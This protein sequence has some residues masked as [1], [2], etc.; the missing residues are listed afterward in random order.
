MPATYGVFIHEHSRPIRYVLLLCALLPVAGCGGGSG[1]VKT[2]PPNNTNV[3]V[4]FSNS[5][6]PIA[7][8]EKFGNGAWSAA[9]VPTAN[10][11]TITLPQGTTNF[12][13]AYVCPQFTLPSPQ[14]SITRNEESVIQA[15]ISDGSAY[16]VS[17]QGNPPTGAVTGIVS[18]SSLPGATFV[19]IMGAQGS[20]ILSGNSGPVTGTLA[21]STKDI[22]VVAFGKLIQTPPVG[23]QILRS[24]SVP[25]AINGGS[26]VTLK[27]A[28][29]TTLQPLVASGVPAGFSCPFYE[30]AYFTANGTFIPLG[31]GSNAQYA[32]VASSTSASGDFYRFDVNCTMGTNG[33]L[34]EV[35]ASQ[36]AVSAGPVTLNVPVPLTVQPPTPAAF[37]S[38]SLSYSGF[39]G[40]SAIFDS[41]DISWQIANSN[42]QISVH[43]TQ[44]FQNGST[45]LTIPDLTSMPGFLAPPPSGTSVGWVAAASGGSYFPFIS[46]PN[47]GSLSTA[48]DSGSYIEP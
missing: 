20:F 35:S 18:A 1:V 4:T 13:F 16:T 23:V 39:A 45:T 38:F 11:L 26:P 19:E 9:T 33:P 22:A 32:A 30:T 10:P 37:P 24:Q 36:S 2:P 6:F 12:G 25:G 3:T 29:A 31:V 21:T 15:Y 34:Q 14:G 28:N 44:A 41:A 5:V 46:I 47:S 7:V 17:C 8:A 42:Y 43:A 27:S 48:S 40:D